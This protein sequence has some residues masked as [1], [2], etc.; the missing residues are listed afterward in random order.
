MRFR[1]G[2]G[3]WMAQWDF[4]RYGVQP[5]LEE[6]NRNKTKTCLKRT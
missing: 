4:A 3:R 6:Y 2:K 1:G 5:D